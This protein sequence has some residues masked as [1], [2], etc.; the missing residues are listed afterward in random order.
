VRRTRVCTWLLLLSAVSGF[1]QTAPRPLRFE[2]ASVKRA[3]DLTPVAGSGGGPGTSDPTHVRYFRVTLQYLLGLAYASIDPRSGELIYPDLDQISGP[4]WIGSERYDVVANVPPGATRAQVPEM[5]RNLLV[6]RFHLVL[7]GTKKEFPG[8]EL[9]VAKGG[10]K[11]K[12]TV[13]MPGQA[14]PTTPPRL[15]LDKDGF[16]NVPPGRH[17]LE[18]HPKPTGTRL[19]FRDADMGELVNRLKW[20]LGTTGGAGGIAMGRLEDKTGLTGRYDFALD[21]SGFMVPGG[22]FSSPPLDA[23]APDVAAGPDLFAAL[24]AQ[25]GLKLVSKKLMLDVLVI[26]SVD[27]VP[28][29]N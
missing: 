6:D 17:Y 19:A 26:D 22:A 21:F 1:G 12:E 14:P 11:L 15:T 23:G 29:E 10:P 20:P 7:H 4:G 18:L 9:V 24:E 3:P 16:P 8:Y 13:D 25:L 27:K 28:T 2:V 5:W